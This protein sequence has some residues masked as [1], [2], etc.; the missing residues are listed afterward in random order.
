MNKKVRQIKTT[1]NRNS[2]IQ[3]AQKWYDRA[4][5]PGFEGIPIKK[6]AKVFVKEL[7][8]DKIGP[9][10]SAVSFN[11]LL[12]FF[13]FIIF[14]FSL[15]PVIPIEGLQEEIFELLK[16]ILPEEAFL[17]ARETIEETISKKRV[18]LLSFGFLA[19]ILFSTNGVNAMLKTFSKINPA[20]K[21]RSFLREYGV[22]LILTLMLSFLFV[23]SVSLA[24]FGSYLIRLLLSK[25]GVEDSQVLYYILL[26]LKWLF[27]ILIYF[28]AISFIYY[29][30]PALKTKWK[31]ISLGGTVATILSISASLGFGFYV[32]QFGQYNKLYG[33]IGTVMMIMVWM[34]INSLV[35]M[36]GF[37]L[38]NSIRLFELTKDSDDDGDSFQFI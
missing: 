29:F 3:K 34:Y 37:E 19:M 36:L 27:I 20:F 2:S 25:L 12:A 23:L 31:F 11:F 26:S 18:D 1:F 9:R 24:I 32:Q 7:Q 21:A 8:K 22:A 35:L 15:I 13:P 38:N 10:A 5:L 6:V 4:T 16:S 33:S 28:L 17:L 30:G 14:I